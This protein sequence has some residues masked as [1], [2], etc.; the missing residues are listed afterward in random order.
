MNRP[1]A[2]PRK[3]RAP[4]PSE[5]AR[6]KEGTESQLDVLGCKG[7][8]MNESRGEVEKTYESNLVARRT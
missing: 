8:M 4:L 6:M 3:G 7:M 1:R 5:K 2:R